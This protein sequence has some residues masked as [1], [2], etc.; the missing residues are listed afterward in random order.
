[1]IDV[2]MFVA[3]LLIGLLT[4]RLAGFVLKHGGHGPTWDLV[5]GLLGSAAASGIFWALRLSPDA[6]A[7]EM[8]IVAFTGAAIVLVAQ[9]T[10]WSVEA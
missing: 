3:A 8:G 4:G 6:G 9:R 2:E 5:L 1:M 7:F 10:L